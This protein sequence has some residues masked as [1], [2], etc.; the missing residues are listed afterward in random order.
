MANDEIIL[1]DNKSIA[2]LA[3]AIAAANELRAS[4]ET[5]G[6][7]VLKI[8]ETLDQIDRAFHVAKERPSEPPRGAA[9]PK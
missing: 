4:G 6:P 8:L 1:L 2:K 3:I 7:S 5:I 9:N